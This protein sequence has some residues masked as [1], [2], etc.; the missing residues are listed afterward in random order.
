[1]SSAA[2]IKEISTLEKS[3]LGFQDKGTY[4]LNLAIVPVV[5]RFIEDTACTFYQIFLHSLLNK[6]TLL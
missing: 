3:K 6:R 1:M 4:V 5:P 2:D